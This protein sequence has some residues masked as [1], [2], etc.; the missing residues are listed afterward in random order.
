MNT[1]LGVLQ[2]I[3]GRSQGGPRAGLPEALGVCGY[4]SQNVDN[5]VYFHH[6]NRG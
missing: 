3:L 6:S 5:D 4:Q 2:E 1:A